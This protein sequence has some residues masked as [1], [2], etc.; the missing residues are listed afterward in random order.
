[1][2]GTF[3]SPLDSKMVYRNTL[4]GTYNEEYTVRTADVRKIKAVLAVLA[5]QNFSNEVDY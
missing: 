5:E 2:H 4:V 1:M 3:G